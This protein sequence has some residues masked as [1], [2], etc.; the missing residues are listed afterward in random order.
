[1][2]WKEAQ[3][4]YRKLETLTEQTVED[5]V[6]RRVLRGLGLVARQLPQIEKVLFA[7]PQY[8]T[9]LWPRAKRLLEY[10]W[11]RNGY[12][13]AL[14][15]RTEVYETNVDHKDIMDRLEPGLSELAV[16]D[17]RFVRAAR[18]LFLTRMKNTTDSFAY[19]LWF[20]LELEQLEP[21]YTVLRKEHG[22]LIVLQETE[23]F[24]SQFKLA[25][26][27][28]GKMEREESE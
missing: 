8:D 5:L 16:Q 24:V 4:R 25:E 2:G 6:A 22:I 12:L 26:V 3:E 20:P 23:R 15:W 14:K 7:D 21:P 18:P 10:A 11:A 1:M 27:I 17:Y 19:S 13:G 9:A 28:K